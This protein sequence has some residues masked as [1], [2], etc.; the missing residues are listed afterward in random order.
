MF[1]VG[2]YI[3]CGSNGV[4]QVENIGPMKVPGVA[5]NRIYYTLTPVYSDSSTVYTPTDNQKI[6]MRPVLTK[7][8]V[9]ELVDDIGDIEILQIEDARRREGVFKEA[10]KSCDCRELVKVIKT[11]YLQKESRIAKGKKNTSS[12]EKY[13]N[14]AEDSLYGE[15]AIP[16]E[17]KRE[18]VGQF[19]YSRIEE[20]ARAEDQEKSKSGTN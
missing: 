16:L 15:L 4:C 7:E 6:V 19:I 13:L 20:N 10:L 18:E 5:K 17:M 1:N 14:I 12:D 3:I 8:E 9:C 11:L 2:E